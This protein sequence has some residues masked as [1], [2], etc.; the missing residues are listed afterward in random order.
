M[1]QLDVTVAETQTRIAQLEIKLGDAKPIWPTPTESKKGKE[2]N[3]E[4][5]TSL[6]LQKELYLKV[7]RNGINGQWSQML[8]K[9]K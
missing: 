2:S 1:G 9:G 4:I 8:N 7:K 5:L 3:S 6:V